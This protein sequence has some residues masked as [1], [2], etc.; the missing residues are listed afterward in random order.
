MNNIY[1]VEYCY[2]TYESDYG[3]EKIFRFKKDAEE[4]LVTAKKKKPCKKDW[5]KWRITKYKVY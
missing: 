2:C 4:Y 1:A 5:Q 3:V